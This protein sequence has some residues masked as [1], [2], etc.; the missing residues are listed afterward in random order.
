MLRRPDNNNDNQSVKCRKQSNSVQAD[1]LCNFHKYLKLDDLYHTID[2]YLK[3]HEG[4]SD[5]DKKKLSKLIDFQK[6]SQ[7][8]GA[9]AAQN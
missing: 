5:S 9:H 1:R 2:L 6:L 3:T 8:A 7:E 4:L